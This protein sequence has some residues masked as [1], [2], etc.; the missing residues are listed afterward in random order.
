MLA[1]LG[2]SITLPLWAA[3]LLACLCI[4][5]GGFILRNNPLKG[6]RTLSEIDTLA[7]TWIA[8]EKEKLARKIRR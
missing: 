6:A 4:L 5:A 1:I 2:P 8:K 7:S 3:F